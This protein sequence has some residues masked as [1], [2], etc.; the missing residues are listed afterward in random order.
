MFLIRDRRYGKDHFVFTHMNPRTEGYQGDV[1]EDIQLD[2]DMNAIHLWPEGESSPNPQLGRDPKNT[3]H[4]KV[5]KFPKELQC[6]EFDLVSPEA[7]IL[8]YSWLNY[9][10]MIPWP[11]EVA[12]KME[13]HEWFD[14]LD[15]SDEGMKL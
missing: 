2:Y 11:H 10:E 12:E 7:P 5:F 15:S 8:V 4:Y 13:L 6:S 3:K 14:L 9:R 1:A